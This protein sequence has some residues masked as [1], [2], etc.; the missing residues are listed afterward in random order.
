MYEL[1]EIISAVVVIAGTLGVAAGAAWKLLAYR[2]AD[3][4]AAQG[5]SRDAHSEDNQQQRGR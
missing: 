4:H 1:I 5:R 2:K 3:P